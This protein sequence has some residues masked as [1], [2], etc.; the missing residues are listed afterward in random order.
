M[1][2]ACVAY[3]NGKCDIRDNDYVMSEEECTNHLE[4]FFTR[5]DKPVQLGD[6]EY[7]HCQ[8]NSGS[9]MFFRLAIISQ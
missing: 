5:L 6:Y 1:A 8:T 4:M 7:T 3:W 9:V 2:T